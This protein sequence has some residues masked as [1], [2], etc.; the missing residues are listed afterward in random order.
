MPIEV[1][2]ELD[3]W[4]ALTLLMA[5]VNRWSTFAHRRSPLAPDQR[6]RRLTAWLVVGGLNVFTWRGLLFLEE[7]GASQLEPLLH[8]LALS[9][10]MAW[11]ST[12]LAW[13]SGRGLSLIFRSVEQRALH[14]ASLRGGLV[15]AGPLSLVAVVAVGG[16][17]VGFDRDEAV[18]EVRALVEDNFT[19][20]LHHDGG[21]SGGT[22]GP[23]SP[24]PETAREWFERCIEEI[25]RGPGRSLYA[26]GVTKA[27]RY[28]RI[29][30]ESA[31]A[32]AALKVCTRGE[33]PRELS[34]FYL[35]AVEN[36]A[37]TY[38]RKARRLGECSAPSPGQHTMPTGEST[39]DCV[40]EKLCQMSEIRP[41]DYEVL[42]LSLTDHDDADIAR[43]FGIEREAA[44]KRRQ[45]A[46]R[47]LGDFARECVR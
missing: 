16:V 1:W 31:A 7:F 12:S 27:A 25:Y 37:R 44:K 30:A 33:A 3:P 24:P 35:R 38:H 41:T 18:T 20:E 26:R 2:S 8:Y 4:L 29:D 11:T 10:L 21:G 19:N 13:V 45:R 28:S 6:K 43:H 42:M 34:G 5:L 39:E 9:M 15:T 14:S 32:D 23:S 47:R 22:H 46:E 17:T 40:L 36:T